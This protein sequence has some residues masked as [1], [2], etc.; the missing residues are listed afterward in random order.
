MNNLELLTLGEKVYVFRTTRRG[1]L[2]GTVKSVSNKWVSIEQ[3]LSPT[4]TVIKWVR[5]SHID[6]V[7]TDSHRP[8]VISQMF[9][10]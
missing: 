9:D 1:C 8:V 4:E 3:S 10:H 2:S 5:L 7:Y 6:R